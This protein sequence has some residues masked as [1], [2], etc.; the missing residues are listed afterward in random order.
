[1]LTINGWPNGVIEKENGDIIFGSRINW[2]RATGLVRTDSVGNVKWSRVISTNYGDS[3]LY[4][5]YIFNLKNP[6]GEGALLVGRVHTKGAFLIRTDSLGCTLPN[7]LDTNLHVGLEDIVEFKKHKLIL[8]PNPTQ[9]QLQIAIN[10][11]G[12]KVEEIVIYD[13]NG[14]EILKRT[15]HEY[16]AN[17]DVSNYETGVYIIKV[18]GT[19]GREWNS[20][21]IKK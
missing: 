7:C 8:Y 9:D 11:Q 16:L 20:K 14:R 21:F 2:N 12:E 4:Y 15:Y 3:L 13:I 17:I 1:V 19:D 10:Q 6:I 18:S 5:S